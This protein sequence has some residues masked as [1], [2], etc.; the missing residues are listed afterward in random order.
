M[1][2]LTRSSSATSR[3]AIQSRNGALRPPSATGTITAAVARR[4]Y[5]HRKSKS[6]QKRHPKQ[7]WK[8]PG[9]R[10]TVLPAAQA[11]RTTYTADKS[12]SWVDWYARQLE[13]SPL[14]TKCLTSGIIS[15]AG[16]F[17][18]QAIMHWRS[19]PQETSDNP[20]DN[21]N[22][23]QNDN[24]D[25]TTWFPWW[26]R[27]RTTHFMILGTNLVGP[28]I[29]VWY[30][31]LARALPG[32]QA[33]AVAQRVLVDQLL[34]SPLF[35][36]VWLTSLWT[37]EDWHKDATEKRSWTTTLQDLKEAWPVLLPANWCLWIPAQMI[38]FRFVPLPYQ[39]LF[40]NGVAF[41]WN[42][43]LSY[44]STSPS[45]TTPPPSHEPTVVDA[46]VA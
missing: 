30:G 29:H 5:A 14:F 16:D 33:W 18:C 23:T 1:N 28:V 32:T 22:D 3:M 38:N 15:G 26:D 36:N 25:D 6:I 39:V 21:K 37:L 12:F 17:T 27:M 19:N 7:Q 8:R 10:R 11:P 34:F 31:Q 4:G 35:L 43:F 45:L 9:P 41:A 24:K 44:T 2:T 13:E 20:N 42:V 40:S 46:V